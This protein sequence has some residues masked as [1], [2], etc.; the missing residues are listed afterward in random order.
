MHPCR[1]PT[2]ALACA[3]PNVMFR[4]AGAVGGRPALIPSMVIISTPSR[5]ASSGPASIRPA[6][7]TPVNC[8]NRA[9]NRLPDLIDESR[10]QAVRQQEEVGRGSRQ[11]PQHAFFQVAILAVGVSACR[12]SAALVIVECELPPE[13]LVVVRWSDL[14]RDGRAA[15]ADRRRDRGDARGVTPNGSF[16]VDGGHPGIARGPSGGLDLPRAVAVRPLRLEPDLG[17][18][19][20]VA[21][22]RADDVKALGH[23]DR[24]GGGIRSGRTADVVVPAAGAQKREDQRDPHPARGP[25]ARAS[26]RA[27]GWTTVSGCFGGAARRGGLLP[28]GRPAVRGT[29]CGFGGALRR[30]GSGVPDAGCDGDGRR[31]AGF[32]A[33]TRGHGGTIHQRRERIRI[34]GVHGA[35]GGRAAGDHGSRR[36]GAADLDCRMKT[37]R[38]SRFRRAVG[39]VRRTAGGR[40]PALALTAVAAIL[41]AVPAVSTAQGRW[42]GTWAA[43]PLAVDPP[44]PEAQAEEAPTP[45]P[46]TPVRGAEP[47]DSAG[48]ADEHRRV[49]GAGGPHEPVRRRAPSRSAPPTSP[50]GP[51]AGSPGAPV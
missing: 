39:P 43:G 36:A 13:G 34:E 21:R 26:C 16:R 15:V 35:R 12:R 22:R 48:R 25:G 32:H 41:L 19:E 29:A 20:Q 3:D 30:G 23:R 6:Y 42:V 10:I 31:P 8:G 44:P 24:R 5:S 46:R 18:D 11:P 51:T 7:G 38:I 1:L 47:D 28:H 45:A 37:R 27:P 2:V 9:G 14:D 4:Q 33:S 40:T 49:A 17:S 50:G